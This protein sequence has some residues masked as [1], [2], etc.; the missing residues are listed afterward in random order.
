MVKRVGARLLHCRLRQRGQFTADHQATVP[1]ILSM[2]FLFPFSNAFQN[3]TR[4]RDVLIGHAV[5][6]LK[7]ASF[8]L[9]LKGARSLTIQQ[10]ESHKGPTRSARFKRVMSD[11]AK[12]RQSLTKTAREQR[13]ANA[14]LCLAPTA[15]SAIATHLSTN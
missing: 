9:A 14:N 11:C 12:S 7:I 13:A 6:L 8:H 15:I 1:I 4:A 10:T 3:I 2:V 5:C